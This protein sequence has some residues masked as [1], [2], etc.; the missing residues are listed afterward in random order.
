MSVNLLI[1]SKKLVPWAWSKSRENIKMPSKVV[2]VN[3]LCS[4]R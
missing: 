3:V 4:K 2:R 1:Y